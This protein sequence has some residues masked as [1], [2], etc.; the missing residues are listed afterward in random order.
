MCTR[1]EESAMRRAYC[2]DVTLW[3][4]PEAL[5]HGPPTN[6]T[7]AG[8]LNRKWNVRFTTTRRSSHN[9]SL[10]PTPRMAVLVMLLL[11]IYRGLIG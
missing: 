3:G 1:P 5:Q 6:P 2:I 8:L 7:R 11:S 10:K 9:K 4:V